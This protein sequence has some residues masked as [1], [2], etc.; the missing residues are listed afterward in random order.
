LRAVLADCYASSAKAQGWCRVVKV[1][2]D[3]IMMD[4]Y[5]FNHR[6]ELE[7]PLASFVHQVSTMYGYKCLSSSAAKVKTPVHYLGTYL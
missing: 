4:L 6:I 3:S 5:S 1:S 7:S 2:T